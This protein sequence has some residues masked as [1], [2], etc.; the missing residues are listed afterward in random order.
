MN[1]L[2]IYRLLLFVSLVLLCACQK[3]EPVQKSGTD[4]DSVVAA[5]PV[6]VKT[7]P[8]LTRPIKL[9]MHE[10]SVGL[11]P[12]AVGVPGG[13]L[14]LFTGNPMLDPLPEAL[15]NETKELLH[16]G[17][18]NRLSSRLGRV[19]NPIVLPSM[20]VRAGLTGGLFQRIV[21]VVPTIN[22]Q[23]QLNMEKLKDFLKLVGIDPKT[24]REGENGTLSG[25][26]E[27]VAFDAVH[28]A[29]LP[30]LHGPVRVYF[31]LG[32]FSTQYKNEIKTPLLSLVGST[33]VKVRETKWTTNGVTFSYSNL[34][35]QVPLSMRPLG[36]VMQRLF[37]EPQLLDQ[38][39][40]TNWELWGKAL[41]LENFF[42]NDQVEQLLV[43]MEKNSLNDAGVKYLHSQFSRRQRDT[44]WADHYLDQAVS[45]DHVYGLEYLILAEE[46]R[47][48]NDKEQILKNLRRLMEAFPDDPLFQLSLCEELVAQK[49]V[50][51]ARMLLLKLRKLQWSE[52]YYPDV[53]P[54]LEHF[55]K[56]AEQ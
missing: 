3:Q 55:Q 54:T 42:Q 30:A 19:S 7:D 31:D 52:I 4:R 5:P 51:E 27:G 53:V 37:A 21:W 39:L 45:D 34:T 38:A 24:I 12:D 36:G 49:K 26:V 40:P 1:R 15:R 29:A 56:V 28:L 41:Y 8:I 33:L 16:S 22:Q 13:T 44:V 32:Y 2:W 18:I 43:K 47:E 17:D 20:I 50:D 11:L 9:A 23:E 46:A 48:K 14:V 6:A 25:T 35:G 10:S